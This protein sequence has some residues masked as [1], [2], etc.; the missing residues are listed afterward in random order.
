MVKEVVQEC[1]LPCSVQA[2]NE[3]AYSKKETTEHFHRTITEAEDVQ[4]T[5]WRE[6]GSRTV[7]FNVPLLSIPSAIKRVIGA[8]SIPVTEIQRREM[9][10]EGVLTIESSPILNITGGS[11]FTTTSLITITDIKDGSPAER[12]S[13][14]VKASCE[15][16]GPW[17]MIGTI[18]GI[19]A[20]QAGLAIAKFLEYAQSVASAEYQEPPLERDRGPFTEDATAA[21][22]QGAE[23]MSPAASTSYSEYFFDARERLPRVSSS[24][25]VSGLAGDANL[26]HL[27]ENLEAI[28][29]RSQHMSDDLSAMRAALLAALGPRKQ[30]QQPRVERL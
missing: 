29:A 5:D 3:R 18:E 20:E 13:L 1:E 14:E 6:D 12:C 25:S 28:A 15:A 2:Y 21:P 4:V 8:S 26:Q 11:K 16:A 19:M 17:G 10:P 22:R 27:L 9:S 23:A 7:K 30:H 24:A